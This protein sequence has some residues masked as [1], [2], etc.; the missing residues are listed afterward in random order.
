[1]AGEVLGFE[2]GHDR[3]LGSGKSMS[4]CICGKYEDNQLVIC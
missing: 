1:M 3:I 2:L 4:K